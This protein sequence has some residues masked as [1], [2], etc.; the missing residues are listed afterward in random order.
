LALYLSLVRTSDLLGG[1]S[2]SLVALPLA[3]RGPDC[4]AKDNAKCYAYG[5]VAESGPK[6]CSQ[7]DSKSEPTSC[8][9]RDLISFAVVF[10]VGM[11]R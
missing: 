10:V 8:C 3:N 1:T 2:W 5:N 6:S 9:G 7:C 11:H 4:R